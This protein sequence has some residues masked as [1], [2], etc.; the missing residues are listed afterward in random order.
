[1]RGYYKLQIKND[2]TKVNHVDE[3][4]ADKRITSHIDY[5]GAGF[6][7]LNKG[8]LVLV[9]KGS[10][11]HSLVEVLYKISDE[12][13]IKGTSFGIDY[14]IDVKSLFSE[15]DS[16]LDFKIQ[17]KQ[18]GYDGTF[19]PLYDNTSKTFLLMKSWY[20]YIQKRNE[21]NELKSL[22]S[23]KKQ[24]I[25]QGPPGT[26]KTRLAEI[27]AKEIVK[28]KKE[29]NYYEKI[30][31]F[32]KNTEFS[33]ST[34]QYRNTAFQLYKAFNENFKRDKL[35]DLKVEEYIVGKGDTDTF[36]YWLEFKL[37]ELGL[38]SGYSTKF[39]LFWNDSEQQYGKVGFV[40]DD[41]EDIAMSKIK[42][43]L[44]DVFDKKNLESASKK[45]S[46][47][48]V[49]KVLN[50]YYPDEHFPILKKGFIEKSLQLLKVEF[51]SKGSIFEKNALLQKE[52]LNLKYKYDSEVSNFEFMHFLF[53]Q[54]NLKEDL[55]IVDEK[56]TSEGEYQIILF[57]PNYSYEDF[58]RGIVT[59]VDSDKIKYVVEN[60]ILLD[61]VEKALS[62]KNANY[63]LIVDEINRAN[64]SSVLGEL[65]YALEYRDKVVTGLYNL[66]E[67]EENHLKNNDMVLPSNL[68][69]IGTMNTADRS[70][71][72][73]DYAIR[74]RF[75]FV[76]VLPKELQDDDEIYFNNTDFLRISSLF[77]DK[78]VSKE[79][80]I[81][82]VRIGHSYFIVKKSDAN[83][84]IRKNELFEMK[85]Q[86]EV[87]PI[88]LEYEKDGI[89]IGEYEGKSMKD[90]IKSL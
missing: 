44:I 2:T 64:L 66:A 29:I 4:I 59:K 69:I 62:N 39:K 77:N 3:V 18:I 90:Y 68:Y 58:V 65:I 52:F 72:H 24:I 82:A 9:H 78:N 84:D 54:F 30:I 45:M 55:K 12:K 74:R 76:D 71:G 85:M 38:Y 67:Y 79:F 17:N 22:L 13:E 15:L 46:D 57:H 75:A 32:F 50:S 28:E 6:E 26:G 43:V 5:A 89:L 48:F 37:K 86:Y 70:V 61:F 25:L 20:T 80:E 35:V 51:D 40:K 34:L 56:I 27:L 47:A 14:R 60:K 11:P 19:I 81:D 87:K 88:L 8:D 23:Y 83:D 63:V 53:S 16:N 10:Y 7:K 31:N 49:L 33:E 21:I 73:I 42:K 1:M 36:C 41:N